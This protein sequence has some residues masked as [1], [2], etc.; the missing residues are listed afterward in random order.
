M[1]TMAVS[2]T[3]ICTALESSRGCS[4]IAFSRACGCLPDCPGGACRWSGWS[5]ALYHT[6][7]PVDCLSQCTP[8]FSMQLRSK[9]SG[10]VLATVQCALTM[11]CILVTVL[12]TRCECLLC[13]G[14]TFNED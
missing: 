10:V 3:F 14:V 1:S 8:L 2:C 4:F 11:M 6:S 5:L 7:V 13:I 9:L 12:V